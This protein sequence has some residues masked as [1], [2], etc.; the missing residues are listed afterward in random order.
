[1]ADLLTR[2][3][4]MTFATPVLA[5]AGPLTESGDGLRACLLGGA[6]GVVARTVSLRPPAGAPGQTSAAGAPRGSLLTT[7]TWSPRLLA[8]HVA[9]DYAQAAGAPLIVSLGNGAEDVQA[10]APFVRPHAHAVEIC[11]QFMPDDIAQMVATVRAAR[12][13]FTVP[14]WVKLAALGRDVVAWARA[15][16]D[17]GADAIVAMGGFGPCLAIDAAKADV[18]CAQSGGYAWLSG[19]AVK[20]IALRC[21]WDIARTLSIPV[22][23]C[24]GVA[25][26]ADAVEFL[27]AG[28]SAVQ[29]CAAAVLSGAQVFGT[30]GRELSDWMDQHGFASVDALRGH[31]LRRLAERAVR[32]QHV[33]P[34]LDEAACIG[35]ELCV[36]SCVYGALQMA[37]ERKSPEYKV[38]LIA[39]RCWGCGLCATRCPTRALRMAGVS[40]T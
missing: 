2:V 27:M 32:T 25:R 40:L 18:H 24:G 19:A 9:H 36:T 35:C 17:A 10:L 20:N 12:T 5:A 3:A 11:T 16:Q 4:G 21:V 23:G 31:A 29:V 22:I 1:M 34:V 26:G 38:R 28:A 13:A 33:P 8:E 37:G 15:A 7:E 14:V 6:A 39:E 30:I